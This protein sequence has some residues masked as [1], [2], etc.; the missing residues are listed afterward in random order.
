MMVVPGTAAQGFGPPSSI[1]PSLQKQE[2]TQMQHAL[3]GCLDIATSG[4]HARHRHICVS[5]MYVDTSWVNFGTQA[6]G[7]TDTSKRTCT[8]FRIPVTNK[9]V[10]L[11]TSPFSCN[12]EASL[13][14]TS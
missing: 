2:K 1:I 11:P 3:Q 9:L 8:P 6:Q 12:T 7:P 14:C 4:K 10:P 13:Y 5:A